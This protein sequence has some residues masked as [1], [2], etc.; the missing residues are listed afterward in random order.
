MP[1]CGCSAGSGCPRTIE[2]GGSHLRVF[3]RWHPEDRQ[4]DAVAAA[5]HRP[6]PGLGTCVWEGALV[7]LRALELS[8]S[9]VRGKTVLEL[10]CGTGVTSLACAVLGA[11]RVVA[12]DADPAVLALCRKNVAAA[13]PEI[14]G[15]VSVQEY[16][17]GGGSAAQA[18][19]GGPFDVVIGADITYDATVM[20]QLKQ[21]IH[22][23]TNPEAGR[24]VLAFA[25]RAEYRPELL[26]RSLEEEPGWRAM[27]P[28]AEAELEERDAPQDVLDRWVPLGLAVAHAVRRPAVAGGE[29]QLERQSPA[30]EGS[31]GGGRQGTVRKWATTDFS[32]GDV[33]EGLGGE[34]AEKKPRNAETERETSE[35]KERHDEEAEEAAV[36]EVD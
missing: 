31:N 13:D 15:R 17:W 22:A 33:T 23:L 9:L 8:P 36:P 6:P 34:A 16:A 30:G 27:W 32:S 26:L 1:V 28:L 11:K 5:D 3:Q 35:E 19:L 7:L 4:A 2:V 24:L 18:A 10:G 14:A 21:D 25:R 12:T 20:M 29:Q